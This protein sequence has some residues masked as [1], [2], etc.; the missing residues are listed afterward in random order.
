MLLQAATLF[1][2][3]F[4]QLMSVKRWDKPGCRVVNRTEYGYPRD[5]I[6]RMILSTIDHHQSKP[7]VDLLGSS[8]LSSGIRGATVGPTTLRCREDVCVGGK[9]RNCTCAPEE[10]PNTWTRRIPFGNRGILL[11]CNDCYQDWIDSCVTPILGSVFSVRTKKVIRPCWHVEHPLRRDC[12]RSASFTTRGRRRRLA[13][14]A[15][16]PSV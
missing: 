16:P 2:P 6:D 10:F 12:S 4:I 9:G 13:G 8:L 11:L 14:A 3:G 1:C 7:G 5:C 15:R